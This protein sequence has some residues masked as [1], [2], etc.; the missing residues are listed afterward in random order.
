MAVT[1]AQARRAVRRVEFEWDPAVKD[2]RSPRNQQHSHLGILSALAA[3]F[4]CGLPHLRRAEDFTED[5]PTGTRRRW[6]LK[7]RVSDTTL[8]RV[9][10]RQSP[11]GLRETVHRQLQNLIDGK[12]V[13]SDELFG[14]GVLSI[15]GKCSWASTA[16]QL[17]DT[18][19]SEDPNTGL[20]TS[21]LMTLRAVLTSSGARPCLDLD[22]IPAKTGESPALRQLLPRVTR[23]F[24]GQFDIVTVDAGMTCRENALV[25]RG[26]RK[27]YLMALKGN[28]PA[29]HA[30]AAPLF[31]SAEQTPRICTDERRNG[32]RVFRELYTVKVENLPQ[33][34]S[35]P[36]A[37]EL[38]CVCQISQ[39]VPGSTAKPTTETR[40]FISSMPSSMLTPS[41][42]LKLVRLHWGIENGHHWTLDVPMEEDEVQPCQA[43]RAAIEVVAW[44]RVIAFNLISVWRA[45]SSTNAS[46]KMS[47]A[48]AMEQLRDALIHPAAES[49][50]AT[51]S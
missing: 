9:L 17:P 22:F 24:G 15:D 20:V 31:R 21:S 13:R 49:Y 11:A 27:H 10:E 23:K 1:E 6:G 47:W 46:V 51:L 4:A 30:L 37:A 8:Y 43:S 45:G 18:K 2:P 48:R 36:D 50:L 40:Y 42:K 7:R 19:R 35:F 16:K 44:L 41:E 3:A 32:A 29:L 39:P 38:W 34:V 25:I 12:A 28:Q 14:M 33:E 26:Q 5:L